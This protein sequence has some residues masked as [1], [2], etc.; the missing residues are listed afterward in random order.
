[1]TYR[2]FN[3]TVE[4]FEINSKGKCFAVGLWIVCYSQCVD[5]NQRN[6]RNQTEALKDIQGGN[7]HWNGYQ[8]Q[9][10]NKE[11][12]AYHSNNRTTIPRTR[13]I[14][15]EQ[16]SQHAHPRIS[17]T[18][19]PCYEMSQP[20]IMQKKKEIK[21]KQKAHNKDRSNPF[22]TFTPNLIYSFVDAVR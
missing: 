10:D 16:C 18:P 20:K 7:G 9:N 5:R 12:R 19:A 4:G 13:N 1:M 14:K 6:D 3:T 22:D 15:T 8:S 17:D 21:I 2:H 11:A